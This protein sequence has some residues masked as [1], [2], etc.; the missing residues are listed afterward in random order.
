ME[1]QTVTIELPKLLYQRIKEKAAQTKRSIE[2]ELLEVVATAV[3]LGEDLPKDL[4]DAITPL[5][6]L[7]DKTLWRAAR[8][9]LTKRE[10]SR[11]EELHL[12]RQ[13]QDLN[14]LEEEELAKLVRKYERTIL[15][16]AQAAVILKERG[17]DISVLLGKK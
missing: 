11:T 7:D 9:K 12:K 5:A 2:D 13:R 16:R 1:T 3:P 10:S 15:V 14:P 8:S 17:H 4:A 6:F